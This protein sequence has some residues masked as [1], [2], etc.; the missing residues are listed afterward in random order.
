ML[1]FIPPNPRSLGRLERTQPLLLEKLKG[2]KS[3]KV[4]IFP[5]DTYS[6]VTDLARLRG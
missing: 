1:L 6:T 4:L 3:Q 2:G 5:L